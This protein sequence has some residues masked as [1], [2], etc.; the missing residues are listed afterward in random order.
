MEAVKRD[1]FVNLFFLLAVA[2][3]PDS[4]FVLDVIPEISNRA[5]CL[6]PFA[7]EFLEF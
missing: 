5:D 1:E 3:S 6:C 4:V 2:N 7:V